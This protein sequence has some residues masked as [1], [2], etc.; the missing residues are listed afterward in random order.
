MFILYFTLKSFKGYFR[1]KCPRTLLACF[2]FILIVYSLMVNLCLFRFISK[3]ELFQWCN[4]KICWFKQQIYA[5]Y[6]NCRSL[7]KALGCSISWCQK[8]QKVDDTKTKHWIVAWRLRISNFNNTKIDEN[9]HIKS[10][11]LYKVR[12]QIQLHNLSND[13]LERTQSILDFWLLGKV[14]NVIQ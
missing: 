14:Q 11:R 10:K 6:S 1:K 4:V 9:I 8:S 7:I 12:S 13:Y 5:K 3:Y 2:L